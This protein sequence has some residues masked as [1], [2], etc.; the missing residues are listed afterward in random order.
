MRRSRRAFGWARLNAERTPKRER[1]KS[2]ISW[3]CSR[4]IFQ[5]EGSL[6]YW[7]PGTACLATGGSPSRRSFSGD[8][9]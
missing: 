2:E 3:L 6:I 5:G 4:A 8:C 7:F 9:G 1:P